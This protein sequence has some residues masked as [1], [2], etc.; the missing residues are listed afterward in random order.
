M[1]TAQFLNCAVF[2]L[3]ILG[4]SEEPGLVYCHIRN[5]LVLPRLEGFV[6]QIL[7]CK[8]VSVYLAVR[9]V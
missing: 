5:E 6:S 9:C 1:Q 8:R 3:N 2:N 7:L 4:K